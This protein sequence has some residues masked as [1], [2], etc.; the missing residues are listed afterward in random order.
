MQK[1]YKM[2]ELGEK[3]QSSR[4]ISLS[5]PNPEPPK[6]D[7]EPEPPKPEPEPE[8]KPPTPPPEPKPASAKPA[9]AKPSSAKPASAKPGSSKPKKKKKNYNLAGLAKKKKGGWILEVV[10]VV[11]PF[12]KQHGP[13]LTLNHSC[14]DPWHLARGICAG[15]ALRS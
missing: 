3:I 9:S 6:P 13:T 4:L 2:Q 7:P 1:V 8:P 10:R 15:C 5:K 12:T 14:H 11:A